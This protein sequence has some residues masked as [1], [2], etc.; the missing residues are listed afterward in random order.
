MCT[1]KVFCTKANSCPM[2]LDNNI[3][4]FYFGGEKML[5]F[6]NAAFIG[7]NT[8]LHSIFLNGC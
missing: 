2:T 4:E 8:V 6:Y 1:M 3:M 7:R 5:I